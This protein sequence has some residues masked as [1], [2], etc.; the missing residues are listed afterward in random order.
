MEATTLP[1]H[2]AEGWSEEFAASLSEKRESARKFLAA[3][4]E[5][6]LKA[7]AA[8]TEQLQ[9]VAENMAS[10]ESKTK[11]SQAD[12]E[13][14]TAEIATQSALLEK[15]KGEF[16]EQQSQWDAMHR[17]YLDDQRE[18]AAELEKRE[19]EIARR[20]EDLLEQQKSAEASLAQFRDEKSSLD[21]ARA[22][23]EVER[24]ELDEAGERVRDMKD[25]LERRRSEI[26]STGTTDQT[27]LQK[28]CEELEK[29]DAKREA[30][31]LRLQAGIEAK[32]AEYDAQVAHLE[33]L[34]KEFADQQSQ[35][36]AM[37][38]RYL[39]DQRELA[40]ALEKREADIARQ[41]E[42]LHEQQ[43]IA[44]ASLAELRKEKP[45]LETAR[46]A[47]DAKGRELDEAGEQLRKQKADLERRQAELD[48]RSGETESARRRIAKEFKTSRAAHLKDLE[49]LRMELQHADTADD[50]ALTRRFEELQKREAECEAEANALRQRA[51]DLTAEI[52][53]FMERESSLIAE[54]KTLRQRE[55]ELTAEIQTHRQQDAQRNAELS[56]LHLRETELNAEIQKLRQ[57]ETELDAEIKR[58]RQRE[59]DL[60]SEAESLRLHDTAL[61]TENKTLRLRETDL[62]AEVEDL[63]KHE[64]EL[65]AEAK[66]LR[67]RQ[68]E[69]TEARESAQGQQSNLQRQ[70]DS[71]SDRQAEAEADLTAAKKR[72]RELEKQLAESASDADDLAE[73]RKKFECE[74]EELVSKVANLESQLAETQ[75]QLEE[76]KEC[77]SKVSSDDHDG[78]TRRYEM[79]MEDLHEL[80]AKNAELQ[81]QLASRSSSKQGGDVGSGSGS[82]GGSSIGKK[83]GAL[84]WEAEKKR[85]LAALESDYSDDESEPER[86]QIE[87]IIRKT[88]AVIAEKN[89]EIEEL[90]ML[91]ENQS[92]N[93]G[94]VAVGAAALGEMFDQ[95]AIIQEERENLKRIQN[96]WR[97]KVKLAEV[98]ISVERAKLARDKMQLDE[99]NR[100]MEQHGVSASAEPAESKGKSSRGKWLEKLGLKEGEKDK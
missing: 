1:N 21:A 2:G 57:R 20:R 48:A 69:L 56:N 88:D 76:A 30:E 97:E 53:S 31:A 58:L 79:A 64:T 49:R 5:R 74:R 7:E 38:R 65:T 37:H 73:L 89:N 90:K 25:A 8:L 26:E 66:T 71:G 51:S 16:A 96:E 17:R 85:I 47:L 28:H 59:A 22:K 29:R 55:E 50:L 72:Y 11:Q 39:E 93:L 67:R 81:Q 6:L 24:R 33:K 10:Q 42:D 18:M 100:Q 78:L 87:E 52:K 91:L 3:Q 45:E 15:L 46:A 43:K 27:E 13:A 19:A 14:K 12:L 82:G 99:R 32:A 54:I 83:G 41:R 75:E 44:E 86:M 95:D 60:A 68:T 77:S 84:D 35:W 62:A 98:E 63:R 70:L 92:N 34:K 4:Q 40:A 23:L 9:I 80:K 61:S 94:N 36:E